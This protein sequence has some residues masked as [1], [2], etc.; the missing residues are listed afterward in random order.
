ML[1]A[2]PKDTTPLGLSEEM[3][4]SFNSMTLTFSWVGVQYRI[5]IGGVF[6]R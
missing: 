4:P 1:A 5:D 6:F 3:P 2:N